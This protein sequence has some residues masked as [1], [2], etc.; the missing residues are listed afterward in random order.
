MILFLS[1][2][3]KANVTEFI[4]LLEKPSLQN[5]YIGKVAHL[6]SQAL[7]PLFCLYN[8]TLKKALK[9]IEHTFKCVQCWQNCLLRKHC[10]L[11]VRSHSEL[12]KRNSSSGIHRLL[13]PRLVAAAARVTS[14]LPV[15]PSPGRFLHQL[16]HLT[17]LLKYCVSCTMLGAPGIYSLA[18]KI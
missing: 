18:R 9:P 17:D 6:L 7:L 5:N 2:I 13:S 16:P 12:E 4:F 11:A 10:V 14:L 15:L 8:S 1:N 3:L